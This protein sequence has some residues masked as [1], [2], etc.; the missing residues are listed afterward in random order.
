MAAYVMIDRLAVT[1]PEM[2]SAYHEPAPPT[3]TTHGGRYILPH[4]TQI[5]SL[6]GKRI[7]AVLP[8]FHH[9]RINPEHQMWLGMNPHAAASQR[10]VKGSESLHVGRQG[11]H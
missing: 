8:L 1:D 7:P 10:H 9:V 11:K 4:G 3:V 5:E 6:E 2:F